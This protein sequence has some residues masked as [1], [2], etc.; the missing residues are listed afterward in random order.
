[1]PVIVTTQAAEIRRIEVWSQPKQIVLQDPISKIPI[2]KRAGGVAQAEGPE[3]KSQYHKKK[4]SDLSTQGPWSVAGRVHTPY[5][6]ASGSTWDKY[7]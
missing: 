3:F 5:C 1:M 2:T 4:K 6:L 7:A